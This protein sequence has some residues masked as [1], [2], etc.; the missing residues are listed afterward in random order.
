MA[1]QDPLIVLRRALTSNQPISLLSSSGTEV[2][3]LKSAES[4]SLGSV[5]LP[6]NTPTRFLVDANADPTNPA[7]PTFDLQSLLFG[8]NEREA[9]PGL[10]MRKTTEA[11][12]GAI[13]ITERRVVLDYLSGNGP[14]EGPE[15]RVRPSPAS[16]KREAEDEVAGASAGAAPGT[17][18]GAPPMKKQ[19]YVPDKDDQEKVKKMAAIVEGAPYGFVVGPGEK[20]YEKTGAVYHNR[21]TVLRGERINVRLA[22]A[23][24]RMC[25]SIDLRTCAELRIGPLAR[26]AST[27]TNAR[28]P[29]AETAVCAIRHALRSRRTTAKEEAAQPNHHDLAILDCAHH[30]AQRQAV[31]RRGAVCCRAIRSAPYLTDSRSAPRSFIPSEEA[32][33][34]ASGGN[35]SGYIAEDVVQVNHARA[36]ASSSSSAAAANTAA[37]RHARYFVVDSV[38]AL[39]KFGGAGKLDEAW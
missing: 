5:V 21:E 11:G 16:A 23:L 32:R 34:L 26:R 30:H 24:S 35:V 19:R 33:R 1:S 22:S 29:A 2:F 14:E 10:Y 13:P 18:G 20:K 12:V 37:T 39:S 27:E 28:R 25:F 9:N 7:A 15:G 3:D 8:Y 31:P 17:A 36:S 6:K 38:E 4:I